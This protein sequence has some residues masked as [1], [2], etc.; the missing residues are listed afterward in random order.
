VRAP[1]A[2]KRGSWLE[3]FLGLGWVAC[4]SAR[5]RE[6]RALAVIIPFSSSLGPQGRHASPV[7]VTLA[8][9]GRAEP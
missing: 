6:S 8:H 2:L 4:G 1:V 7:V 5:V 9:Q 3:E